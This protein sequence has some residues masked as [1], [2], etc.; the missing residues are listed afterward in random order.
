MAFIPPDP[1]VPPVPAP[2][3]A[4]APAGSIPSP[5]LAAATSVLKQAQNAAH[6]A[7]A[8][9]AALVLAAQ[10]VIGTVH[11]I[12]PTTDTMGVDWR[13]TAIAGGTLTVSKAIDSVSWTSLLNI[14]NTGGTP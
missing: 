5:V 7:L 12:S 1:V 4:S 11:Q 3:V 8:I 14:F 13:L 2:V 6:A 9:I 10:G